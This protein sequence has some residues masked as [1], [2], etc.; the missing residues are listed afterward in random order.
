MKTIR[1]GTGA[2]FSGDRVEPAAV[3]LEKGKLDY[4]A[5]E[6]LAER[7]I[8][9]AQREKAKDP[10]KGY[11]PSMERRMDRLLPLAHKNHVKIITNMGVANGPMAVKKIA[12]IAR[13]HGISG[14]KIVGVLGDDVFDR[15]DQYADC[16]IMETGEPLGQLKNK[17]SA[18]A[19]LGCAPIVKALRQG[20]DVVVTG[21]CSDPSL[22]LAPLVYEFGW[23]LDDYEKLGVGTMVG[24]LL[25][26][27]GQVSG[28]NFCMPGG[29]RDVERLWDI[30]FPYA[31]VS[32][33]GTVYISKVEGTGGRVDTQTCTEQ[34]LYEI[35]D[36]A[37]YFTAD[38][39]ADFSNVTFTDTA[40]DRVK[41]SGATG[42][43]QTGMYK[44]SGGYRDGYIAVNGETYGGPFCAERARYAMQIMEELIRANYADKLDEYK[45]TLMGYDCL[46]PRD[47]KVGFPLG[48][49]PLEVRVRVAAR[50]QDRE[51]LGAI[52]DDVDSL[53]IN[54]PSNGGAHERS[55]KDLV[56]V[57]SF[58]IPCG[59]I[60]V[61]F[62]SEEV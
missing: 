46:F 8:A 30:G 5:F 2:G 33:D 35:H 53:S 43:P 20:A 23:A 13:A 28:G 7:T 38:C 18:N 40:K 14:M 16:E 54:G 10:T 17:I 41:A 36:P 52:L 6:C 37:L 31:D 9:I 27:S 45:I 3:L 15:L 19:Y 26:C 21:R 50:A 24:H 62:V 4:I 11:T 55:L 51:V 42:R 25:E 47:A 49:P 61:E 12:Q 58:L 57:C 44:V 34:L 48:V 22:F 1:I 59:D 32:E 39:V 60:R 56:A 29:G